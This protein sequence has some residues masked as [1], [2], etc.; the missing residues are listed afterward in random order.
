MK[1]VRNI[2]ILSIGFLCICQGTANAL[3]P[4][5]QL[6]FNEEDKLPGVTTTHVRYYTLEV[7]FGKTIKVPAAELV[8]EYDKSGNLKKYNEYSVDMKYLPDQNR[9]EMLKE[10]ITENKTCDYDD[11]GRL[12]TKNKLWEIIRYIYNAE[13]KLIRE[14]IFNNDTSSQDRG[15]LEK[16]KK[17]S[18]DKNGNCI[19]LVEEGDMAT[20]PDTQFAYAKNGR[21]IKKGVPMTG[22]TYSL[23][24]AIIFV[25]DDSGRLLREE[26]YRNDMLS[27]ADDPISITYYKY[28]DKGNAV[29]KYWLK[30]PRRAIQDS[31]ESIIGEK[32]KYKYDNNGHIIS[33]RFFEVAVVNKVEKEI[34]KV[35]YEVEYNP[36]ASGLFIDEQKSIKG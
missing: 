2:L 23:D 10:T 18:Y 26:E 8:C 1:I 31:G 6:G 24:H 30:Y 35:C 9:W 27:S 3:W 16:V 20:A 36:S 19:K 7:K 14:E 25:Y 34:E 13:G 21:M 15:K 22:V 11:S 29:E 32:T 33:A 5:E 4:F 12:V 17:Y 28:D